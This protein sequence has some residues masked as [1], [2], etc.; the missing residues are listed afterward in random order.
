[1]IVHHVPVFHSLLRG[2]VPIATHLLVE[3]FRQGGG[4]PQRLTYTPGADGGAVDAQQRVSYLALAVS[5]EGYLTVA[6]EQRPGFGEQIK[7]TC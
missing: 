3:A 6:I 1:M 5:D 4:K 2:I 7:G